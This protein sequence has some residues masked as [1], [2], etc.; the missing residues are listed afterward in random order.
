MQ[1]RSDAIRPSHH[2]PPSPACFDT[3]KPAVLFEKSVYAPMMRVLSAKQGNAILTE[4][5]QTGYT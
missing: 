1:H 4:A 2:I 3:R 5:F